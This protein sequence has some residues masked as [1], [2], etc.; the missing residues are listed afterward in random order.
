[1]IDISS[2]LLNSNG[3]MNTEELAKYSTSIFDGWEFSDM[4]EQCTC[5]YSV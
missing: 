2:Q 4:K 1:M 5:K 3:C